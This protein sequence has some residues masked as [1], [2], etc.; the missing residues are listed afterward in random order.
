MDIDKLKKLGDQWKEW[1]A[2]ELKLDPN[3][4]VHRAAA[5]ALSHEK[6]LYEAATKTT[7]RKFEKKLD[8]VTEQ[9]LQLSETIN[10]LE[11]TYRNGLEFS[12]RGQ[13]D[14]NI[15]SDRIDYFIQS[16]AKAAQSVKKI[17]LAPIPNGFYNAF[18]FQ[19]VKGVLISSAIDYKFTEYLIHKNVKQPTKEETK[20]FL[21]NLWKTRYSDKVRE[22][23]IHVIQI[24][25]S[26]SKNKQTAQKTVDAHLNKIVDERL[27]DKASMLIRFNVISAEE[28]TQIRVEMGL[29]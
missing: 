29:E 15:S 2:N 25:L 23:A 20:K 13:H 1:V 7:A 4:G 27:E 16:L 21:H 5:F 9:A 19:F 8:K 10:S 11:Y 22:T 17:Y 3:D 28:I 26:T 12:L 18:L 14:I 24:K 6:Y